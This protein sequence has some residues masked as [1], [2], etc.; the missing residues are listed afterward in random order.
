MDILYR[1]SRRDEMM[2]EGIQNR[3]KFSIR[4]V[5]T[6]P[7]SVYLNERYTQFTFIKFAN[8]QI[9]EIFDP[10]MLCT[11]DMY[12]TNQTIVL[13]ML[14]S[15]LNIS[16][17]KKQQVLQEIGSSLEIF[18]SIEEIIVPKESKRAERWRLMIVDFGVGRIV[19]DVNIEEYAHLDLKVGDYLHANGRVDLVSIE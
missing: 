9:V 13:S 12:G 3:I 14:V 15:S 11:D 18:G 7:D 2:L 8:R 17:V 6:E 4:I 10:G 1:H 19:L 16:E 5:G